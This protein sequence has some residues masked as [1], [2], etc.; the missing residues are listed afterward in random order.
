IYAARGEKKKAIENLKLIKN[1][2]TN[3]LWLLTLLKHSPFFDNIRIEPE[4]A[5]ILKEVEAKYLKEHKQAGKLIQEYEKE[6]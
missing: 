5:D 6:E 4:F 1:R 2:K 3:S